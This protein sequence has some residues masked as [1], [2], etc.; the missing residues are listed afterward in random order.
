[1]TNYTSFEET[2][3]GEFENSIDFEI[4][5]KRNEHLMAIAEFWH[6]CFSHVFIL[7]LHY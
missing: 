3:P 4:I 1:M 7:L 6:I 2:L 5:P